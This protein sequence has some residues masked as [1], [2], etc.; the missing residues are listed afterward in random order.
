MAL[1]SGTRL[2]PFEIR[3]LLGAGAM[4]EVYRA[5]DSRLGRDVAIKILAPALAMDADAMERF[6]REA[7]AVAALNHPNIIAL[8]DIGQH[9]STAYV[10]TEL[11]EGETLRSRIAAGPV[12]LRKALS[13][14]RQI[15]D[16]IAAAHQR[17]IVHRDLKPENVFV[18]SDGRIKVLDFGVAQMALAPH[19]PDAGTIASTGTLAGAVVGSVGYMAP[20]QMRGGAVDARADIFALGCT[21]SELISGR[22][23]FERATPADTIAALM[24]DEPPSL[25]GTATDMP[26]PARLD[27]I[28][29]RC[30]EKSPDERFQSGRDLA[31]ALAEV[32]TD[33]GETGETGRVPQARRRSFGIGIAIALVIATLIVVAAYRWDGSVSVPEP[34]RSPIVFGIPAIFTWSD[35]ASVSPD[36]QYLVYTGG[37]SDAL[38]ALVRAT[39]SSAPVSGRFWVRRLDSLESRPLPETESAHGVFF[40]SPDSR[41]LGYRL[42]NALVVR[43]L[44]DGPARVIAEPSG[45]PTGVAWNRRGDLIVATPSGLHRMRAPGGTLEMLSPMEPGRELW[46][47]SPAFLPDGERFLFTVLANGAGEQALDTR[48]ADL[49]GRELGRVG[50]G[51]VGAMYADGYLVFGAGGALYAQRFDLD[52]L[53]LQG[54]RVQIAPSVV[55]DWRGGRLAARASETGVLVFMNAR[56]SESQFVLV[57][58]LGRTTRTIAAPENFSNFDVSPDRQRLIA[59]RIDPVTGQRSLSLIDVARG[60]TSLVTPANDPEGLD[61]PTWAPDG[62]HIAYRY[63]SRL[64]TRL[65]NG[66]TARTLLDV[67]GYPDAF[68]HDGRFLA[69]GQPR[70]NAFEQS[71]VDISKP[72]SAPIP[73][74]RGVTLAD[75]A[76]FSPSDRWIAYHSNET[77]SPEI[78]VVP[79]PPTGEKWQLSQAGGVQPR[80]SSDGNELFFLD[81]AGRL[82]SVRVPGSDPRRAAAPEPLFSTGFIPSDAIDQYTPLGDGFILRAPVSAGADAAA[83]Q[84]IV[85][86]TSL[87]PNR[88]RAQTELLRRVPQ[89]PIVSP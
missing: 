34:A 18:T 12:P 86:W 48:V 62:Q 9:G 50:P 32:V 75:E 42:G 39:S 21:L 41:S 52:R 43:D 22:R 60:V 29:R 73:L 27:R 79:F 71:V 7:R 36:G 13:Y 23:P 77:R 82:M 54:E 16:A 38:A 26:V 3:S 63:G 30:L 83:V 69:Y 25:A 31:F 33:D 58:R 72:G 81:P 47:G 64:V 51:M 76:R 2:G 49:Q 80:W 57:D 5:F 45:P 68:S 40:W 74:V 84:V 24:H 53:A 1:T 67:E 59:T 20:E 28:V 19:D 65:A 15:A 70:G 88:C 87:I 85:N 55:Q 17:G 8:F 44:P 11:L 78:Y 56:R 6:E 61:D 35:G 4:G 66:G 14:A 46:R 89:A 10:V 37:T